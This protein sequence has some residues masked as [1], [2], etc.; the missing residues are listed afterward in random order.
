MKSGRPSHRQY[1]T[2]K[3]NCTSHRDVYCIQSIFNRVSI[4]YTLDTNF[5]SIKTDLNNHVKYEG[6]Y[7]F[8]TIQYTGKIKLI[9]NWILAQHRYI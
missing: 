7:L 2:L 1:Y 6:D 8:H 9:C 5:V 4:Y 3:I